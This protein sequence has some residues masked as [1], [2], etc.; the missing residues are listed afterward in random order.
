[1]KLWAKVLVGFI[2]FSGFFVVCALFYSFYSSSGIEEMKFRTQA[3]IQMRE[4]KAVLSG[5]VQRQTLFRA[6]HGSYVSDLKLLG[7]QPKLP[8]VYK[9]GFAEAYDPPGLRNRFL[10]EDYD[11]K[12]KDSDILFKGQYQGSA[13]YP[14]VSVADMALY[15]CPRCHIDN[16]SYV[17]IAFANLDED[18]A[19]DVWIV[20]EARNFTHISNDLEL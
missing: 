12:R 1:M 14:E 6:R 7:Y 18:E 4:A 2:S 9:F 11:P 19:W 10:N 5:I 16:D 17:A 3:K 13:N 15:F 8:L 20:D